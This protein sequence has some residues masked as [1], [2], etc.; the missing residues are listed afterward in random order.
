MVVEH[1]HACGGFISGDPLGIVYQ[2][3]TGTV[4]AASPHSGLCQ[5]EPPVVYGAAPDRGAHVEG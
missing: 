4:L 5:C 2:R 3:P 1:C